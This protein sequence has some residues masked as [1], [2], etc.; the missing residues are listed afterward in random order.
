[1]KRYAKNVVISTINV[2]I[3]E[4]INFFKFINKKK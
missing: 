2:K 3:I 4:L 1:M